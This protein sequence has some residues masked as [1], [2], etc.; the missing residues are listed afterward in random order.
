MTLETIETEQTLSDIQVQFADDS[1][2]ISLQKLLSGRMIRI[3]EEE[4][5]VMVPPTELS[6]SRKINQL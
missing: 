4:A 2:I 5:L 3:R 6:M 1:I